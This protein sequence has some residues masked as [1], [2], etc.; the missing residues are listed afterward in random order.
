MIG[1]RYRFCRNGI[2]RLAAALHVG[3]VIESVRE[4][5]YEA[6]CAPIHEF[7]ELADS[8]A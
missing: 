4:R 1:H 3:T 7:G 8:G 5:V 2:P 6:V